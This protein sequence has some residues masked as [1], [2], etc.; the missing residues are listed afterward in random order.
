MEL[1]VDSILLAIVVFQLFLIAFYLFKSKRG[2]ILS[3]RL[4]GTFFLLIAI[5]L[6]D[7]FL[8]IHGLLP[9]Y[10]YIALLDDGFLLALGPLLFLYTKSVIFKS[11]GLVRADLLHFI[12]FVLVTIIFGLVPVFN[13]KNDQ[14]DFMNSLQ[15]FDVPVQVNAV[16]IAMHVHAAIY[17]A[18]SFLALKNYRQ[19]IRQLFASLG[20]IDLRWL[21]FIHTSLLVIL[22]VGFLH[23]VIPIVYSDAFVRVSMI[24]F[25]F[26]LLIFSNRVI[27]S[28]MH[29]STF[30]EG[31]AKP[32][33]KY[34]QSKLSYHDIQ[35]YANQLQDYMKSHQPYLD[36]DISLDQMAQ[37]LQIS[38]KALSQVINQHF[39][40]N[41]YDYINT[42]RI[43]F[44]KRLLSE[45]DNSFTILEI[46]Y[47]SG[48]NSKSSFNTLFKK[49]TG[50]TPTNYRKEKN[51]Q[52]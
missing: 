13:S 48:F 47:R 37:N 50:M 22:F 6:F 8:W 24:V 30:F 49:Y 21:R 31:I 12:P 33:Q 20:A 10:I 2:K 5:N 29:Q 17:L 36:A 26:F 39:N 18:M 14:L 41:F 28:T 1:K 46:L 44:S 16:L 43:N 42:Y 25:I 19:Q 40:Q 11:Y 45:N 4:F 3:N 9:N 34:G 52:L 38:P 35:S 7:L 51:K 23:H 27:L 32:Y 15:Q